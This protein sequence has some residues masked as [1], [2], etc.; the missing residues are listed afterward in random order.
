MRATPWVTEQQSRNEQVNGSGPLAGSSLFHW[1]TTRNH[2]LIVLG[3]CHLEP[4][5][6]GLGCRCAE[7]TAL[8]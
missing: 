3:P 4:K 1:S 5:Q 6:F 7:G 8:A 2:D